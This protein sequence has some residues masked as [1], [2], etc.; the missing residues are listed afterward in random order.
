MGTDFQ[1]M[2]GDLACNVRQMR[3]ALLS[4]VLTKN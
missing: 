2:I 1:K 3:L 4:A